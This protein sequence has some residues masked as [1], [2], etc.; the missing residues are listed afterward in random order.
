MKLIQDRYKKLRQRGLTLIEAAMVLA[1]STLVVAGIM[2][3]FQS[4]SINS[5][6][7]EAM[8]Q[9][10]SLQSNVRSLYSSQPTYN[11]L[12]SELLINASGVPNKMVNGTALTHAFNAEAA[13]APAS[14][15]SGAN[16]AFTV[17]YSD[18]PSEACVSMA[19]KDLGTGLVSLSVGGSNIPL[20][21]INLAD[22]NTACGSG[23]VA[24]LIWTFR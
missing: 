13:V 20:S 3:F 24:E 22:V 1:I 6:T 14:V 23:G 5:K 21:P 15:G 10:S 8:N 12:N 19:T 9:L 16:N 11:G 18:I 7:N 4:A 17:T 2:V